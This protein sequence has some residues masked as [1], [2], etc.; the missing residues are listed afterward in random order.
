[1]FDGEFDALICPVCRR[2]LCSRFISCVSALEIW[3]AIEEAAAVTAFTLA[4]IH[5]TL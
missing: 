5:L 4:F 1:M 3:R 2:A